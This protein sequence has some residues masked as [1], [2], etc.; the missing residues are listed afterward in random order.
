[1]FTPA[2]YHVPNQLS[3]EHEPAWS[4]EADARTR[5][6]DPFITR[7]RRREGRSSTPGHSRA[8]SR[9]TFEGL[10][11]LDSG[12]ACPV[13]PEFTYPFCT[14]SQPSPGPAGR[15]ARGGKRRGRV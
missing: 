4:G 15:W 7:E 5:T 10:G 14:H 2:L 12:R 11:T 1:M 13:V 3:K 8:R 9:W 6:G